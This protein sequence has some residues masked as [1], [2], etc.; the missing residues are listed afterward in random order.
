MSDT[1]KKQRKGRPRFAQMSRRGLGT[2]HGLIVD[3]WRTL[4]AFDRTAPSDYRIG[5]AH[6]ATLLHNALKIIEKKQGP[7]A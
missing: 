3:A 2:L 7:L 1:R 4:E 6:A 5:A